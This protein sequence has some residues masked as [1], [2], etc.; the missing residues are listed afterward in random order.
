MVYQKDNKLENMRRLSADI[1]I[2]TIKELKEAGFGHIGGSVSIADVLGVLYGGV[3]NIRPEDP[4]WEDRDW[5]V[6]SKGHCGPG[7]YAALALKGYFPLEV[8][9]T[10]NEPGTS[11]PSHCDRLKTTGIDMTTGSLGQGLS[12]SIGIALGN[13]LKGKESYTYCIIGDGEMNEGQVWEGVQAAAH[14]ELDHYILFVDWNKKQLDGATDAICNPYDIEKKLKAFGFDTQVAVGYDVE[15]IYDAIQKAKETKGSPHA[16]VLDTYKGI[17]VNFAE[18][19]E[20]NHYM[21]VD[22]EMAISAIN[23][24]ERRYREGTYPKGGV[25]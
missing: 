20:F 19:A 5:V 13:Q 4:N 18:E 8:L 12:S 7:L 14:L 3:L 23:E 24:I 15:N 16:I 1:R 22:E 17:G 10:L 2:E 21:E 6:L 25:S 11:L 9:K